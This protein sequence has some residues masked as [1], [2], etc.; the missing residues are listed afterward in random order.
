MYISFPYLHTVIMTLTF[1][2]CKYLLCLSFI[3]V[4]CESE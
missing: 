2:M 4:C 1:Y 3:F